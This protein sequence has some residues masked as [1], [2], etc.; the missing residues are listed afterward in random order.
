MVMWSVERR[1]DFSL[2]AVLALCAL[3]KLYFI[4]ALP[5]LLLRGR[6]RAAGGAAAV[7]GAALSITLIFFPWRGWG[8]WIDFVRSSGF[9][10]APHGWA[11]HLYGHNQSIN[12]YL[13]T[14]F[15]DSRITMVLG[16]SLS[17]GILMA[18]ALTA[19][20]RRRL[21]DEQFWPRA[22]ASA[23]LAAFLI[24][25]VAWMHYF[26]VHLAIAVWLWSL[27]QSMGA[28]RMMAV[29]AGLM[30][31]VSL[32]WVGM[33]NGPAESVIRWL[34]LWGTVGLWLVALAPWSDTTIET[35]E[36]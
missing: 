20:T 13:S 11:L 15:G 8:D 19:W 26:I 28:R 35:E 4:L 17:V 9:G 16:I 25:P 22:I 12:G 29:I 6:W 30:V 23:V 33:L 1:R 18:T 5:L 34:P 3:I 14:L 32:P 24:A 36:G 7:L 10:K 21:P 2:G 27:A 31:Y